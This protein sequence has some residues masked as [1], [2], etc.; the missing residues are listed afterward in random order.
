MS[1]SIEK[2]KKSLAEH[3]ENRLTLS[4]NHYEVNTS[5]SSLKYAKDFT[6]DDRKKFRPTGD[7]IKEQVRP[8]AIRKL[9]AKKK[10]LQRNIQ[11]QDQTIEGLVFDVEESRNMFQ[12][13]KLERKQTKE[14]M[15]NMIEQIHEVSKHVDEIY[16]DLE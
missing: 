2:L 4:W 6:K 1:E 15:H 14:Q 5:L 11:F 3:L 16:D 9:D 8:I 7:N 12:Q 13:Q 10:F